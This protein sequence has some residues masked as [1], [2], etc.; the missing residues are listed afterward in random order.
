MQNPLLSGHA[1]SLVES[2]D[3]PLPSG[4]F[5]PGNQP[6]VSVGAQPRHP[7]NA[8]LVEVRRKD[9]SGQFLRVIPEAI[10]GGAQWFRTLLPSLEEGRSLD[11]RVEL[12]RAGQLLA[13]LPP[14]GSWL[15]VTGDRVT[16]PVPPRRCT[17]DGPHWAHDLQHLAAVTVALCPEIIGETPEGYRINFLVEEG[18]AAGSRIDA[19]IRRD[20]GG[21]WLCVRRDGVATLDARM[22]WETA[23]GAVLDYRSGGVLDLGPDGYTRVAAGQLAGHPPFYATPTFMTSHPRWEWLNRIQGFGFGRV[24]MERRT[25]R[26]DLYVPEVKDRPVDA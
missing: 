18:R 24:D 5:P 12:V 7:G 6:V 13:T 15:T 2:P 22:T 26:Y 19:V 20:G 9:E 3:L 25:I 10:G 14:D 4:V 23:D 17:P 11:Y 1:A 21:D 16:S 8:V